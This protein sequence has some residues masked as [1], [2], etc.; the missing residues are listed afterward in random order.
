VEEALLGKEPSLSEG[1]RLQHL[2]DSVVT[3]RARVEQN[4]HFTRKRQEIN[5]ASGGPYDNLEFCGT[6][7]G[8]N[9]PAEEGLLEET[10]CG[11]P[12]LGSL[13]KAPGNPS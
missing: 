11:F 1:P 4:A 2:I 10:P 7:L 5:V 13:Q 3:C 8:F 6:R 9:E 12:S